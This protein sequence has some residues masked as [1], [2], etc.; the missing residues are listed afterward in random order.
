MFVRLD[1]MLT[2]QLDREEA[3]KL[4][5]VLDTAVIPRYDEEGDALRKRLVDALAQ[6]LYYPTQE[7]S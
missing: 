6:N 1:K 2:I 7:A 4:R 3:V 5:R